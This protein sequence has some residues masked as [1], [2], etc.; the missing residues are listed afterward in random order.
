MLQQNTLLGPERGIFPRQLSQSHSP[1]LEAASPD[2]EPSIL[3]ELPLL[4]RS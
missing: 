4:P 1:P 2:I 3:V